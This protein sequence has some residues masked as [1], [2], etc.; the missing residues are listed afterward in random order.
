MDNYNWIQSIP[1]DIMLVNLEM[2]SRT[3]EPTPNSDEESFPKITIAL[4]TY[5]E[6]QAKPF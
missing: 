3:C 1:R 2:A 4:P 6:I 5:G